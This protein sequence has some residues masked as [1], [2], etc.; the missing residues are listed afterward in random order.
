ME[1]LLAKCCPSLVIGNIE[2][3]EDIDTYFA[4]L[5]EGD[6]HWSIS[7]EEQSRRLLTSQLMT[8][9]Q[10]E[11]LTTV[12]MTK[13]KTLQGVHSYDILANPLYFDDFQYIPAGEPD[14]AE[15]IIDNDK[16]EENDAAQS[17]LV[18]VALFLAYLTVDE[19]KN[20]KFTPEGLR[21]YQA[22]PTT[23]GY[24]AV[25]EML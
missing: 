7:E 6:R 14:R 17:D 24:K 19:A 13:G 4:S 25:N 11:R 3:N 9:A 21:G 16:D 10:Y 1:G 18:R 22:G 8:D 12:P 20:F 2:L 15:L 5:D 23:K